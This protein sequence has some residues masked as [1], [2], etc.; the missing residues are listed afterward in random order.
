MII[1]DSEE[2]L[3]TKC[4]NKNIVD[5]IRHKK[6][7][8]MLF[9]KGLVKHYMQRI[10]SKMHKTETYVCKISLSCFDDKGYIFDNGISSL[11]LFSGFIFM[12]IY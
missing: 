8:D 12:G 6:C 1:V 4:V 10:Q 7:V 2:I 11:G 9:G 3:K 5:S